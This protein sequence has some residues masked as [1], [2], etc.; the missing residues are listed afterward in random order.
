MGW[1]LDKIEDLFL[2]V[3]FFIFICKYVIIGDNL[4]APLI[5]TFLTAFKLEVTTVIAIAQIFF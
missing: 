2:F 1:N 3:Q 4:R 5:L